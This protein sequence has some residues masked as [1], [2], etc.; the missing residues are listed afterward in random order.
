MNFLYPNFLYG[1]FAVILPIMVHLFNFQ[2][3]KVVYFSNFQFLQN[4]QMQTKRHSSVKRW[5]LLLL[6][7]LIIVA[8]VLAF[9]HPYF[10]DANSKQIFGSNT[11]CVFVDNSFSMNDKGD[12]NTLINHA[13]IS[14]KQIANAF[15]PSD[16]FVLI[17]NDLAPE[18]FRVVGREDFLSKVDEIKANTTSRSFSDISLKINDIFT[19]VK[20]SNKKFFVIS[21]FQ[22]SAFDFKAVSID[23]AVN[24]NLVYLPHRNSNNISID[25]CWF[26]QPVLRGNQHLVLYVQVRN[27]STSP[28]ENIPLSIKINNKE[29]AT[30]LCNLS[31]NSATVVPLTF[32]V[33]EAGIMNGEIEVNDPGEIDFDNSFYLNFKI[34]TEVNVLEVFET[35]P[36]KYINSIFST[37][38]IFKYSSQSISSV[39]YDELS[40]FQLVVLSQPTAIATGTNSELTKYVEKGGSLVFIPSAKSPVDNSVSAFLK[41][42]FSSEIGNID[43][44]KTQIQQVNILHSLYKNVFD[45]SISESEL[46]IILKHF[47]IISRGGEFQELFK[48]KNSDCV[49]GVSR[50]GKGLFYL[51]GIAPDDVFGNFAHH[52]II[53]P[54]FINMALNQNQNKQ[55]YYQINN[56][57]V[58][59]L[60]NVD[61][62]G[63]QVLKIKSAD[64]KTE[65]V[66]QMISASGEVHL[67]ERNQIASQ[68]NYNILNGSEVLDGVAF[69]FV[70]LESNMNFFKQDEIKG[71]IDNQNIK[72]TSIYDYHQLNSQAIIQTTGSLTIYK[73]LIIFA[74]LFLLVEVAILKFWR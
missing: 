68:G 16:K 22:K 47:A 44:S 59:K 40:K 29:R 42:N 25:S 10:K 54:T 52:P 63:E 49:F 48:T 56:N 69:N 7:I 26:E 8:V 27:Y 1:L 65:I 24:V 64:G 74:L 28:F 37:D 32:S 60:R 33:N 41:N 38:S 11:V 14:A 55:L 39:R 45:G 5:L 34:E 53:V 46:P 23:S 36:N 67:V 73:W 6:R 20:Q 2:K 31:A 71:L 21:D 58:I 17:T 57:E 30:A 66:P 61:L 3:Y 35:A 19:T 4:L 72:N 51:F 9:S 15:S 50:F 62:K 70:S 43:T 18:Q 12:E 13:K